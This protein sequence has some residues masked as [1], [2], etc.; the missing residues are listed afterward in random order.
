MYW[1]CAA[2]PI[3]RDVPTPLEYAKYE[4]RRTATPALQIALLVDPWYL[5]N[6]GKEKAPVGPTL[7]GGRTSTTT[8]HGRQTM[9][10]PSCMHLGDFR[11]AKI[12]HCIASR[13]PVPARLYRVSIGEREVRRFDRSLLA[14]TPETDGGAGRNCGFALSDRHCQSE[15]QDRHVSA[16]WP[17]AVFGLMHAVESKRSLF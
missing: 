16:D 10:Q 7:T 9:F 17:R 5:A 12:L 1:S 14:G 2:L 15:S 13:M 8:Y 11:K 3:I 6:R 4:V